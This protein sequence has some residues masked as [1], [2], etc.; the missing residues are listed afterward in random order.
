M[1]KIVH[2]IPG[3]QYGRLTVIRELER[4]KSPSGHLER[5]VLCECDC[6]KELAVLLG[7]IRSGRTKSC[8]CL[9][10][11]HTATRNRQNSAHGMSQSPTFLVWHSMKQRCNNRNH[12]A[13]SRYGGR[14]IAVCKR[15]YSFQNFL[16]DMGERPSSEHSIDRI[17]N[18]GNY[19]PDNCRWAT[20]TQQ[21]RNKHNNVMLTC[22]GETMCQSEWAERIGIT[23]E[24]LAAR[25]KRGW[26]VEDALSTPPGG[27]RS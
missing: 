2:V 14:G 10:N 26:T 22:D 21:G 23:P 8:G 5:R 19:K 13:Y 11:E 24:A 9:A 6:G 15:W 1:G 16:N 4:Y 27:L 3:M 17:N 25:I 12:E 18:D 20:R 7:S